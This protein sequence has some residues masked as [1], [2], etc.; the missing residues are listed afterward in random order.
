MVKA[1]EKFKHAKVK[2]KYNFLRFSN[3]KLPWKK[4]ANIC[5]VLLCLLSSSLPFLG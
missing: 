5:S 3:L 2:K 4:S 1:F